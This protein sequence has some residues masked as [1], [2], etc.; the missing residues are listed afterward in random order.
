MGAVY[1]TR[2]NGILIALTIITAIA[3]VAV[4]IINSAA[5]QMN[6]QYIIHPCEDGR[7]SLYKKNLGFS[8]IFFAFNLLLEMSVRS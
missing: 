5:M 1:M 4:S 3:T 7:K 8:K 6:E 2:A